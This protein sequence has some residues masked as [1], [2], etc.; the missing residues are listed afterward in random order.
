MNF[1]LMA[2]GL[3]VF[4]LIYHQVTTW[5][6]L[7]PWNDV[8]KYS[9]KELLLES[10]INGLLMGTA[11][12][13]LCLGH[14]G[15]NRW[16][17]LIYYPFLFVGECVDWW[18]PYFSPAFASARKI[19]DYDA[20]FSRTLKLIPHKPGRRTPDTNHIVLHTMTIITLVIVYMDRLSAS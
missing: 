3:S 16:Y 18:I 10:G 12:L 15:F 5:L 8:E 13:C 20:H 6:P 1:H 11:V 14:S 2:I 4:L 9:R 7:F 17:P 19:W